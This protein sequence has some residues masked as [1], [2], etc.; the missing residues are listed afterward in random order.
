MRV[1]YKVCDSHAE[2][3]ELVKWLIDA[4]YSAYRQCLNVYIDDG[5][6]DYDL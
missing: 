6:V 2:A 4:G 5:G 3:A 1:L